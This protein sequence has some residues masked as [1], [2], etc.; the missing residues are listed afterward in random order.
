MA[1]FNTHPSPLPPACS[2]RG[3]NQKLRCH[4]RRHLSQHR[5]HP[6]A[7]RPSFP[8]PAEETLRKRKVLPLRP[9][10]ALLPP[11]AGAVG[12]V[13][14]TTAARA[15]AEAAAAAAAA[16]PPDGRRAPLDHRG[17]PHRR[18]LLF[19]IG[20]W[21]ATGLTAR[22]NFSHSPMSYPRRSHFCR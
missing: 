15:K 8:R 20:F 6:S 19:A 12:E 2:S 21:R 3:V 7:A 1:V 4:R 11:G 22:V 13:R 16:T 5:N 18:W 10:L 17:H 14:S 9:N